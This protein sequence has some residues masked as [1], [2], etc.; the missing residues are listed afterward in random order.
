MNRESRCTVTLFLKFNIWWRPIIGNFSAL[1]YLYYLF[2]ESSLFSRLVIY[3]SNHIFS[4]VHFSFE[5][6]KA[7]FPI[8]IRRPSVPVLY[9]QGK[10]KTTTYKVKHNTKQHATMASDVLVITN[11]YIINIYKVAKKTMKCQTYFPL[12]LTIQILTHR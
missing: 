1:L 10:G 7:M 12:S 5:D 8:T 4:L 11:V 3:L 6:H 9:D 2:K